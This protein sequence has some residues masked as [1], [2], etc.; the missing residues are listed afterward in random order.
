MHSERVV[1]FDLLD[2]LLE[3]LAPLAC[4]SA[5]RNEFI[6][7]AKKFAATHSR[8]MAPREIE[9]ATQVAWNR[10]RDRARLGDWI[11]FGYLTDQMWEQSTSFEIARLHA[12]RFSNMG[13]VL[14]LC[15]GA[16]SDTAA[17]ARVVKSVCSYEQDPVIAEFARRNLCAQGISNVNVVAGTLGE[18][19]SHVAQFDGV[20]CDPSRRTPTSNASAKRD[21]KQPVY[22]PAL[23]ELW[24][25][26]PAGGV[27]GVKVAPGLELDALPDG[28]VREWIGLARECKELVLWFDSSQ[29]C[30][31]SDGSVTLA[32]HSELFR[33][34]LPRYTPELAVSDPDLSTLGGKYLLNPH[35]ALVP[36]GALNELFS[37]LGASLID[38]SIAYGICQ[39]PPPL[40]K[41]L[42]PIKIIVAMPLRV[43]AVRAKLKELGWGVNARL[44]KR[45]FPED[46]ESMR[47]AL[48]LDR[49]GS[50][51]S[52][53]AVVVFTK[54]GMKRIVIL[55]TVCN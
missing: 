46:P 14:E 29:R 2:S 36:S 42:E 7:K 6:L 34:R 53:L 40:A 41:L 17:L 55:G 25:F 20:W 18:P 22:S 52:P 37:N 19:S 11:E 45:G 35:P 47:G 21:L 30:G 44:L 16:G 4:D 54:V 5:D 3:R 48:G 51:D 1:D 49:P 10:Q 39:R 50:N 28:W 32:D 15:T 23:E 38:S 33:P 13:K 9:L 31:L 12:S 24:N 26:R 8:A 27:V 43:R